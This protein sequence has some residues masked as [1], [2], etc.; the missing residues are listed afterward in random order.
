MWRAAIGLASGLLGCSAANTAVDAAAA[1]VGEAAGEA[2]V[3]E[4]SPEFRAWYTSYVAG[5]AFHSGGYSVAPATA[6]YQPGDSTVY[7]M[8]GTDGELVGRMTRAL[9]FVDARAGRSP[10]RTS[11]PRTPL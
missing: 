4:Y 3:R 6:E 2:I 1:E 10:S 11:R 7:R 9:L 5:L 8:E